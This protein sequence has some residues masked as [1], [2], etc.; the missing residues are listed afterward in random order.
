[1][2]VGKINIITKIFSAIVLVL[3]LVAPKFVTAASDFDYSIKSTYDVEKSGEA[4]VSHIFEVKNN[5]D[6]PLPKVLNVPTIGTDVNNLIVKLEDNQK[7]DARFDQPSGKI[8]V[9]L[10]AAKKG[11][12]KQWSFSVK[13]RSKVLKDFGDT[14]AVQIP[15][16]KNL[17]VNVTNQTTTIMAD[18]DLGF[19]ITRGPEP[20]STRISI[21]K[22]VLIYSNDKGP[23]K[24]SVM[25]LFGEK[26]VA[27]VSINTTIKNDGFWWKTYGVTLPPDTS[28]QQ[29][30]LQSIDPSPSNVYLDEDGNMIA[31]YRIGPK[32]SK[33][34]S[35]KLLVQTNTLSYALESSKTISDIDQALVDRYTRLTDI[36]QPV[37]IDY[38]AKADTPVAEIIK[39]VLDG[40][41]QRINESGLNTGAIQIS[42]RTNALKYTDWLIGELRSRHIPARAVLGKV[43]SNGSQLL[44]QPQDHAWVEAYTPG[45][46]WVT[47]DPV[48]ATQSDYFGVTDV[49]HVGLGLWGIADNRPPV[50][51]GDTTVQYGQI[52]FEVPA[53][54][55]HVKATKYMLLPGVA[56]M[57]ITATNAP[58]FI[59]DNV[60]A[61]SDS[62]SYSLGSLAP[63][64]TVV[65]RQLRFGAKAF[66]NEQIEFGIGNSAQLDSVLASATSSVNW[67]PFGGLIILVILGFVFKFT[68]RRGRVKFKPSKESYVLHDEDTGGDIEDADLISHHTKPIATPNSKQPETAKL[69]LNNQT[70]DKNDIEPKHPLAVK[71][72]PVDHKRPPHSNLIQ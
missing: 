12:N 45:V 19:A 38:Q 56:I 48:F 58:G 29:V 68:R 23:L 71:S 7:M 8:T 10:P 46:G 27:E 49:L 17:G 40:V 26:S 15:P 22:Q 55:A 20:T 4:L 54:S 51:L 44:S 1:M 14:K 67:L 28:Q 57:Q 32:K 11:K 24:D 61:L 59:K 3:L 64:Q 43:M 47:L 13:Y 50:L 39:K 33:Q 52:P 63:L 66:S 2:F 9:N 65:E 18:L 35:A 62:E 30:I 41:T 34:I 53:G 5:T 37:G 16:L 31:Y 36:W 69:P 72:A 42:D 21:G 60:S 25:L 6:A 70:F